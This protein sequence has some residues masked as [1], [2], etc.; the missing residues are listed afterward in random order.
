VPPQSSNRFSK[1]DSLSNA[2]TKPSAG[3]QT[4]FCQHG[5]V[6]AGLDG[7]GKSARNRRDAEPL[8]DFADRTLDRL[9]T[10]GGCLLPAYPNHPDRCLARSEGSVDKRADLAQLLDWHTAGVGLNGYARMLRR[11]AEEDDAYSR[12]WHPLW[13]VH[14]DDRPSL[15]ISRDFYGALQ[16][17]LTE[18]LPFLALESCRANPARRVAGSRLRVPGNGELYDALAGEPVSDMQ[19]DHLK[20]TPHD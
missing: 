11:T 2:R 7:M 12:S 19:S 13:Q 17:W 8:D 10:I 20:A 5:V 9:V 18:N 14:P 6:A 1:R 3:G 16:E 4:L 15:E